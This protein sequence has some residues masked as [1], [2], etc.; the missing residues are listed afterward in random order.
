MEEYRE[1]IEKR[2][3]KRKREKKKGRNKVKKMKIEEG[4]SRGIGLAS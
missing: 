2:I 4:D 1:N 3:G